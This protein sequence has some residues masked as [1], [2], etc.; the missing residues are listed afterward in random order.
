MG[1]NSQ[2]VQISGSPGASI[3]GVT[4]QVGVDDSGPNQKSEPQPV[5]ILIVASNPLETSRLQLDKEF[6][7][8]SEAL[9][10]PGA[11]VRFQ[12]EQRWAASYQDL[13]DGLLQHRPEI[14]HWSGHGRR[15]GLPVLEDGIETRDLVRAQSASIAEDRS[16]VS[17]SR[18]FAAARGRLRCV[19]LNTCH[20]KT[21]ANAIAEHIDCVIGMNAAIQDSTAIRFSWSFYHALAL[22]SSVKTAFELAAAQIGLDGLGEDLLPS[23]IALRARPEEVCFLDDSRRR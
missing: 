1:N 3:G 21:V 23:L 13:Q 6:K 22:G 15:E 5:P 4:Q 14:L 19:V 16:I 8:I 12:V 2:K 11:Q 17:L 7:A 20:S 18:L 9:T 10:R